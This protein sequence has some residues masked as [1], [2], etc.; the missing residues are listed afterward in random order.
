MRPQTS[1]SNVIS[2]TNYKPHWKLLAQ[3]ISLI[4]WQNLGILSSISRI[5]HPQGYLRVKF[6]KETSKLICQKKGCLVLQYLCF[7]HP[8]NKEKSKL[9]PEPF[10]KNLHICALCVRARWMPHV[11]LT[12]A[13]I[14]LLIHNQIYQF[15][16]PLCFH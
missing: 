2:F 5:P 6:T 1:W 9:I 10:M 8:T 13:I 4:V 15:F 3:E 7:L 16:F 11:A 14:N 12:R